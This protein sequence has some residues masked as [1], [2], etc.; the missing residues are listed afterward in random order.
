VI[1]GDPVTGTL[2]A[3]GVRPKLAEKL[4][5]AGISLPAELFATAD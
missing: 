4:Q 5:D 3:T 2:R 1:A